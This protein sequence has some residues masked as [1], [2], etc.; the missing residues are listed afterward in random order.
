VACSAV[1]T[2]AC[3]VIPTPCLLLAWGGDDARIRAFSLV[4]PRGCYSNSW[5]DLV[6]Q[7]QSLIDD[8]G[9]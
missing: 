7:L 4:V 2:C 8:V 1:T 3:S 5:Q 9:V 6:A